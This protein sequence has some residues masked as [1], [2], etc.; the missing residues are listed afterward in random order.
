MDVVESGQREPAFG[1]DFWVE[2]WDYVNVCHKPGSA[3]DKAARF[4]D[5]HCIEGEVCCYK[6]LQ[7]QC[8]NI[9]VDCDWCCDHGRGPNCS[10]LILLN[11]HRGIGEMV[12]A[13]ENENEMTNSSVSFVGGTSND[14]DRVMENGLDPF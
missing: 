12:Q 9:V 4:C 14:G 7:N 2:D 10:V 8:W 13:W 3:V 5:H 1:Q 6:V 11:C